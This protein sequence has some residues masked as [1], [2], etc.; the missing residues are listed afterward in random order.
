MFLLL[1]CLYHF[2]LD[3][4]TLISSLTYFIAHHLEE[5]TQCSLS[6]VFVTVVRTFSPR[7]SHF[8]LKLLDHTE[9]WDHNTPHIVFNSRRMWRPSSA[10]WWETGN[11]EVPPYCPCP[12]SSS[13]LICF[14]LFFCCTCTND[15][16]Q[17]SVKSRLQVYIR[18]FGLVVKTTTTE[19]N[20]LFVDAN[21][22]LI[23]EGTKQSSF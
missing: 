17:S 14:L 9:L 18:P 3:P 4:L 23:R 8:W 1:P 6:V 12:S 19:R 7:F 5:L 20:P 22:H 13:S 2:S 16:S 11:A 21:A 10:C 15:A